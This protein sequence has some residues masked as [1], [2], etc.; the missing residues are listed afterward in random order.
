MSAVFGSFLIKFKPVLSIPGVE[1][2]YLGRPLEKPDYWFLGIRWTSRPAYDAFVSGPAATDWHASLRALVTGHPIVSPTAEYTGHV[3]S[4]LDAPI[5]EVCTCW[6]IDH[7]FT[8]DNMKPFAAACS[9]GKLAGLHGLAY[10]EFVQGEHEDSSV[11]PGRAS[12]LLM[13]WD[14]KEAHLQQKN[15]GSAIDDN[16]YYLRAGN[17]G[18]EMY[19]VPLKKL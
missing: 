3:E 7:T 16:I 12:R 8:E 9:E 6:D 11:I 15:S 2:V 10:G 1:S 14:S 4:A 19:H 18:L 13:G 17:K 5:T